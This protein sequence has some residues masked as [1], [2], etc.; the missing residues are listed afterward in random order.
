MY[1]ETET[2]R[3]NELPDDDFGLRVFSRNP[4]H[5]SATDL[6]GKNVRQDLGFESSNAK[7]ES[8]TRAAN[9]GGTA[10]PICFAISILLPVN[11]KLCGKD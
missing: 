4:S 5:Y 2:H 11:L 7:T 6:A 8:A 9:P 10:L 3:V 1:A